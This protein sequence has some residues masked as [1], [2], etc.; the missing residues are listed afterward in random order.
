ML[1]IE[2]IDLWM[3]LMY[4]GDLSI[5]WIRETDVTNDSPLEESERP[6]ACEPSMSP[7][8]PHSLYFTHPL[9]DR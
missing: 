8:Y 3:E 1:V 5:E 4:L 2:H 9:Y 7:L 6:D